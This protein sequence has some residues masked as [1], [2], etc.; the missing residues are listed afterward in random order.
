MMDTIIDKSHVKKYWVCMCNLSLIS[1]SGFMTVFTQFNIKYVQNTFEF[2][3]S[4]EQKH[5]WL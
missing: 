2:I 1:D 5:G 3:Q 4:N